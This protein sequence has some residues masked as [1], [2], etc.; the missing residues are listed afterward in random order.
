MWMST[1]R[2]VRVGLL[3]LP[4]ETLSESARI[5]GCVLRFNPTH[6]D[7]G[8]AIDA[9]LDAMPADTPRC[10]ALLALVAAHPKG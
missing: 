10:A 5:D 4:D 6:D 9:L 7:V 2:A 3:V 1:V 8:V